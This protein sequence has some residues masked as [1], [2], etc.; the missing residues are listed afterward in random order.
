MKNHKSVP[1]AK[2][3]P[4]LGL[5]VLAGMRSM[6]APALLSH[7]LSR[8][9]TRYLKKSSLRWLQKPAVAT[10]LKV[11]A[12]GELVGDKM[13]QAPDRTAPPALLGRAASGALVGA[14]WYRARQGS[15]LGGA[16]LG[17]LVA[18]ASAFLTLA[19]R[20]GISERTGTPSAVVGLGEDALVLCSGAA[21][22][23]SQRPRGPRYINV[24][25]KRAI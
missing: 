1:A 25:K 19:L 20:K 10:T 15:A 3:W 4:V 13:P 7:F 23:H 11:M 22:L 17:G 24:D 6:S 12:A 9:P 8:H 5:A 21:L 16:V 2:F 14:T 18:V